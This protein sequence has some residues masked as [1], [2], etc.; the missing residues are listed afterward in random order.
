M[1]DH[2]VPTG[3]QPNVEFRIYCSAWGEVYS[4]AAKADTP[5]L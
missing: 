2:Q 5:D 1:L 4:A 3:A